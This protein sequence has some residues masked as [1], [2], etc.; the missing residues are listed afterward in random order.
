MA[1]EQSKF[2]N[3]LRR[4]YQML[5]C[6]LFIFG[7]SRFIN[8]ENGPTSNKYDK[9][10]G[11]GLF[12]FTLILAGTAS[13]IPKNVL[14]RRTLCVALFGFEYAFNRIGAPMHTFQFWLWPTF[15]LALIPAATKFEPDYW[16]S[17]HLKP[18]IQFAIGIVLL[19]YGLSGFWKVYGIIVDLFTGVPHLLTTD[20]LIYQI[21]SLKIKFGAKTALADFLIQ[22]KSF[23]IPIILS[24]VLIQLSCLVGL[25]NTSLHNKLGWLLLLFH[26][27]GALLLAI[28]YP[29]N[30]L[31]IFVTLLTSP[32]GKES[33]LLKE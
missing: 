18:A 6:V 16:V 32:F 31:L 25:F 20:G 1:D 27:G 21:Y 26:I 23:N 13:R 7:M 3:W 14:I 8:F 2:L 11:L 10:F 12:F 29:T 4:F 17:Q 22:N 5:F 33:Q 30:V 19:F 24:V 9:V 28:P 15:I